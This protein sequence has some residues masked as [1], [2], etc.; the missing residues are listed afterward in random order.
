[1]SRFLTTKDA[2]DLQRQERLQKRVETVEDASLRGLEKANRRPATPSD[3]S[4]TT[5]FA[6]RAVEGKN[7][8]NVRQRMPGQRWGGKIA[9]ERDEL[10]C[11]CGRLI[12]DHVGD[13]PAWSSCKRKAEPDDECDV[14]NLDCGGNES[15]GADHLT[16]RGT[17]DH[18]RTVRATR[19]RLR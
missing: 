13:P 8:A 15:V 14:D 7:P 10:Y 11:E 6:K 19:G 17:S 2:I 5:S 12:A 3:K 18:K 16:L 1:M 9:T 4:F